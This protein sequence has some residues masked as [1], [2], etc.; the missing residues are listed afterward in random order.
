MV[1]RDGVV[2]G[3]DDAVEDIGYPVDLE[4]G[5][6]QPL[7]AATLLRSCTGDGSADLPPGDYELWAVASVAPGPESASP[8]TIEAAGGPWSVT[9]VAEGTGVED[10]LTLT[11]GMPDADLAARSAAT[12]TRR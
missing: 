9:L 6:S 10:T 7:D 11:C 2:V 12:G 8:G 3:G 1:T 4:P 5:A